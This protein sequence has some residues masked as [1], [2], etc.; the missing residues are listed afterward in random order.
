MKMMKNTKKKRKKNKPL[1]KKFEWGTTNMMTTGSI[2]ECG[3]PFN[4]QTPK[5]VYDKAYN[6]YYGI[7]M[8]KK[9]KKIDLTWPQAKKRYPKLYAYADADKDGVVNAFDCN[10]FDKTRQGAQHYLSDE[11]K[12]FIKKQKRREKDRL[13]KRKK[14]TKDSFSGASLIEKQIARR[15]SKLEGVKFGGDTIHTELL[16]IKAEEEAKLPPDCTRQ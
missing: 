7:P 2:W 16:K 3:L 13:R 5:K 6:K 4:I 8:P 1:G 10:P 15:R 9:I 11:E 14:K 12:E